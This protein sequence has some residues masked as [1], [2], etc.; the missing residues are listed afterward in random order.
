MLKSRFFSVVVCLL[1]AF[2]IPCAVS[3]AANVAAA[4]KP[5]GKNLRILFLTAMS[6]EVEPLLSAHVVDKKHTLYPDLTIY[7]GK[8]DNNNVSVGMLG[9]GKVNAAYATTQYII[10]TK[11]DVIILFGSAGGLH[12][13]KRGVLFAAAQTWTYDYGAINPSGFEHWQSGTLPIGENLPPVKMPVDSN[14]RSIVSA[15]YPKVEWVTVATGDMFINNTAI[16][17]R[18]AKEGADLVDMESSVVASVASRFKIPSLVLRVVSDGANDDAKGTFSDSLDQV[19][20]NAT[21]QILSIMR[22]LADALPAAKL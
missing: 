22:T 21:P 5:D 10:A 3:E 16:S 4:V 15:K 6:Q 17:Q 12:A 19:C 9:I 18:I 13:L 11:P 14:I 8:L 7:E 20:L 1:F 2:S